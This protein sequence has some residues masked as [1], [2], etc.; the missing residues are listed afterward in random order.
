MFGRYHFIGLV[1]AGII[2]GG[3]G[4]WFVGRP[5]LSAV[6]SNQKRIAEFEIRL[7][8]EE[9]RLA[10]LEKFNR[11]PE[12][13]E[14]LRT[15]VTNA[16]PGSPDTSTFAIRIEELSRSAGVK[17]SNLTTEVP[18]PKKTQEPKKAAGEEEGISTPTKKL[19][20]AKESTPPPKTGAPAQSPTGTV[21]NFSTSISGSYEQIAVWIATLEKLAPFSSIGQLSL[22]SA[23][24]VVTASIA[25]TVN[26]LSP[27]TAPSAATRF[28]IPPILLERL[29]ALVT[30]GSP[31]QLESE[32]G[33]GKPNPFQ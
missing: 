23:T 17:L 2:L 20:A 14:A 24:D 5:A 4:I 32:S 13:F 3:A 18:K 9:E 19:S 1:L 7:R 11:D 25:G 31:I 12:Q 6:L 26:Y 27:A 30:P 22:S 21:F 8:Q 10:V 15:L 28:E 16:L 33:F 29:R